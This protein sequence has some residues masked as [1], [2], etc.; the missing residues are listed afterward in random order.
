MSTKVDKATAICSDYSG[1]EISRVE[2]FDSSNP[3]F[4]VQVKKLDYEAIRT[5]MRDENQPVLLPAMLRSVARIDA[6][7]RLAKASGVWI[8][9]LEA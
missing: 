4:F 6:L 8:K 9:K 1:C 7:E 3:V 2:A 5:E